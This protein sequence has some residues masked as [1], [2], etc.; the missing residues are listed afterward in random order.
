M[1]KK[2][3]VLPLVRLKNKDRDKSIKYNFFSEMAAQTVKEDF[4]CDA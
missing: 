1:T 2:I 3:N 4:F